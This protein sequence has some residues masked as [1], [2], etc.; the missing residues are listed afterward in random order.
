MNGANPAALVVF[1][2]GD[3]A[4]SGAQGGAQY[5]D[6]VNLLVNSIDW[7]SDDTGLIALRT[8]GVST[9]PIREEFLYE[10]AEGRRN[11]VKYLNFGLPVALVLL[12]GLLRQQQRQRL[13][14]QREQE[15]YA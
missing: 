6:N 2:D 5:E 15:S 9:R 13:R 11:L 1:T 10:D 4:L 12:Y 14:K 3:F 7:L 8:K